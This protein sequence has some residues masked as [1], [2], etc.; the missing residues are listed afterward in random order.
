MRHV[1]H[2]AT[3]ENEIASTWTGAKR[4]GTPCLREI[5]P[6]AAVFD[7]CLHMREY[8]YGMKG[9]L[10]GPRQKEYSYHIRFRTHRQK[11]ED[12][13]LTT[14]R[15]IY[16]RTILRFI[17]PRIRVVDH[18]HGACNR[19]VQKQWHRR[20]I[21]KTRRSVFIK[22]TTLK[23]EHQYYIEFNGIIKSSL[24]YRTKA[25]VFTLRSNEHRQ[26]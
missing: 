19:F 10:H 21:A 13:K 1:T 4:S 17:P 12:T 18:P 5:V 7:L 8:L 6:T 11:I 2:V 26:V 16:T 22:V 9:H 20:Q 24:M 15:V 14:N 25:L 3:N 23:R